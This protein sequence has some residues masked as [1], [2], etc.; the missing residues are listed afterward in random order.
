MTFIHIGAEIV[1]FFAAITLI[2]YFFQITQ[3]LGER[4]Q[5]IKYLIIAA[6]VLFI[7]YPVS[8]LSGKQH[9]SPTDQVSD[10]VKKTQKKHQEKKESSKRASSSVSQSEKDTSR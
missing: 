10:Q 2:Y 7:A 8:N 3:A 5:N 1:V 6:V 4:K 9:V